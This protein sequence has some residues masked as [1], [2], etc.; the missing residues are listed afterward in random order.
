[1]R[2]LLVLPLALRLCAQDP[3]S[4]LPGNYSLVFENQ[5]VR[6]IRVVYQPHEKLEI[7]DHP[8]TPTVYVYLTDSGPVKF[9]HAEQRSF[10]A[11]RPAE[12]W[13]R[14]QAFRD[15]VQPGAGGAFAPSTRPL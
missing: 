10:N 6:V 8:S 2:L 4:H 14:S 11:T 9:M 13:S 1:M 5:A 7:H 15:N 12:K 3:L